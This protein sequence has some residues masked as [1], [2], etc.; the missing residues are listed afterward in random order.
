MLCSMA[1]AQ[2]TFTLSL[3][4]GGPAP[5]D[6]VS[7]YN[8]YCAAYIVHNGDTVD[9][10]PMY[11]YT[12]NQFIGFFH[13]YEAGSYQIQYVHYVGTNA[14]IDTTGKTKVNHTPGNL[15]IGAAAVYPKFEVIDGYYVDTYKGD[16]T[17]IWPGGMDSPENFLGY[18]GFVNTFNSGGKSNDLDGTTPYSDPNGFYSYHLDGLHHYDP[19]LGDYESTPL[20]WGPEAHR[21]FGAVNYLSQHANALSWVS[22]NGNKGDGQDTWPTGAEPNGNGPVYPD[23]AKL[24]QWGNLVKYI[25]QK[26]MVVYWKLLE[27][28]N[29]DWSL[30]WFKAYAWELVARFHQF[31]RIVWI[32]SE[33]SD[34]TAQEE[35]DRLDYLRSICPQCEL[36]IHTY[37]N[38]QD[39]VF[40]PL[41]YQLDG[42]ELQVGNN[43]IQG[44]LDDWLGGYHAV[45]WSEQGGANDG[46]SN[47]N[48]L[49]NL[50]RN[51]GQGLIKGMAGMLGYRG[52]GYPHDDLDLESFRLVQ[53]L[54]AM[55]TASKIAE[56]TQD[57]RKMEYDLISAGDN[58]VRCNADRTRFVSYCDDGDALYLDY[59]WTNVQTSKSTFINAFSGDTLGVVYT[60]AST[61]LAAQPAPQY[62]AIPNLYSIPVYVVTEPEPLTLG[63]RGKPY[64]WRNTACVDLTGE[65]SLEWWLLTREGWKLKYTQDYALATNCYD[66]F[67]CGTA[68][69]SVA[70]V[71]VTDL[72]TGEVTEE[73]FE[74]KPEVSMLVMSEGVLVFPCGRSDWKL[75]D[76]IGRKLDEGFGDHFA[77]DRPDLPTGLYYLKLDTTCLTFRKE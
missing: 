15:M 8:H 9:F 69:Y 31:E 36:S 68:T 51:L 38:F 37:P 23:R 11:W 60:D 55:Y 24:E 70:K 3:S 41:L 49:D 17:L 34:L 65:N 74:I 53:F 28:E 50:Q 6:S 57:F 21:I 44:K 35:M 39:E 1:S 76:S 12:G 29:C 63:L 45:S 25:N 75:Y 43:G 32:L 56:G 13:L 72:L 19:H 62:Y 20:A 30:D 33:E 27:T 18:Y 46:I 52:Y 71:K 48:N 5:L 59:N 61:A 42:L 4:S 77:I 10:V 47:P 40:P 64:T 26:D 16:T 58:H 66:Y 73:L 22:V 14:R 2:N 54:P 67:G 7:Q